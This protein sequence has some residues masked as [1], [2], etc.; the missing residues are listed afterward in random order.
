MRSAT[1]FIVFCVLIFLVLNDGKEVEAA[2][3]CTRIEDI[4]GNCNVNG[5]KECM[6]FMTNKY[7]TRFLSC[8]CN[9]IYMLQKTKRFCE[10]K[11]PCGNQNNTP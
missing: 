3:P 10:C 9:N 4:E 8:A 6:K 2:D 5:E 7:K 1:W 11:Y